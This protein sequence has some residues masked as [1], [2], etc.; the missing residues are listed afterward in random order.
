MTITT[1]V[2]AHWRAR[3]RE[4]QDLVIPDRELEDLPKTVHDLRIAVLQLTA[5]LQDEWDVRPYPTEQL[6]ELL[7]EA[8][9]VLTDP[10]S[11]VDVKD[12]ARAVKPF[13]K[14]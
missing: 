2:N 4:I 11:Q 10:D 13:L 5:V 14:S 1:H 7:R 3:L 8:Y 6:L 9:D 12:W